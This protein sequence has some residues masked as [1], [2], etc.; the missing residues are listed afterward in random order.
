MKKKIIVLNEIGLNEIF[1]E[2]FR[3]EGYDVISVLEEPFLYKKNLWK[4]L[5]NIYYRI[6]FKRNNFYGE[7]YYNELNKEIYKRLKKIETEEIDYTLVFRADYYSNKNIKLLRSISKMIVAY[8]YDGWELGGSIPKHKDYLDKVFFFEKDDLS[9]F[10]TNAFPLTNCYFHSNEASS[11]VDFD[12]F[13]IGTGTKTRIENLKNIYNRL[14]GKYKIKGL[15]TIPEYQKENNWGDIQFSHKGV[16][17][18][19]NIALLKTAKCLIDIKFTYHD[20]LSFRFFEALYY[21][22]KLITNNESVKK[23]DFY[24]ANNIFITNFED[25]DGIEEFLDKP[26]IEIDKNIVEKYGFKNWS[27]YV[28][29]Q[30]PYQEIKLP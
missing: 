10:G 29:D 7:D 20:G 17:Y 6:I 27:R 12:I 21:K 25:L 14:G 18:K 3:N 28:L 23:Y 15:V 5:K 2:A 1:T 4:K 16:S 9:K 24:N 30:P 22:K 8:Q 19:E 26:Y 13:Y 11:S